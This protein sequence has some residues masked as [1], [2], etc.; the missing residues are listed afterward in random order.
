MG[1]Y[2]VTSSEGEYQSGSDDKVLRNIPGITDPQ[3]M[4]ILETDL[5]ADLYVLVFDNFPDALDFRAVCQWHST[6]L[7]NVY[8]WAGQTRTVDMSKPNIRFASPIQI[9]R[10]AEEFDTKYLARFAELPAMDDEQLVPNHWITACGTS[11]KIFIS[12]PFKQDGTAITNIW[13]G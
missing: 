2:N 10:L 5:L 13:N 3:E 8:S 4:N 11:T 1:R 12:N 7:G 9:P 6:W